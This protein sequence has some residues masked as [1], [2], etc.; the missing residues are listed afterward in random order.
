MNSSQRIRVFQVLAGGPWG[1]GA[2][3]VRALTEELIRRG[4]Q[5]WV[6]CLS[7]EVSQRFSE[8]GAHVVTSRYWRRAINPRDVLV[9]HE[10]FSLCRRTEFDVVHTHTS[11]GGFLGRIAAKSAGVAHII[12]TIHGFSFNELT[13]WW[14]KAFY[15][16]LERLA[17]HFGDVTISV[18]EQHR[19]LAIEKGI[20]RP[21]Q[22]I[23]IHNGI[24]LTRFPGTVAAQSG[25]IGSDP[26]DKAIRIGTVGRLTPQKGQTYL[27]RA[28]P[29]VV[30]KHPEAH[31]LF[32]G[33]G[34]QEDELRAMAVALGV[35]DH[36][37]FL[38]FRRDVPEL[39]ARL[40]V[41]VQPSPR[42]G[43]SIT[44]LEAM[45]AG[46]PVVATDITGNQEVI[47]DGING[48]LCQPKSSAALS[49]AI[50]ALI[51]NREE[52]RLLG[53]RARQKVEKHFDQRIMLEQTLRLYASQLE[54][55]AS[56]SVSS[57]QGHS[58]G[59]Q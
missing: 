58:I 42:E 30:R 40:D 53:A 23:T 44:L 4:S 12:H 19:A 34:P 27:L 45:A 49:E 50:I 25:P 17:S 3:V 55:T 51:D 18:T 29:A 39:L 10:L 1:G 14:K 21:N 41:F 9:L 33:D 13:P 22:V 48:V 24:D 16:Q 37:S 35:A 2:V 28:F 7:E 20:A 31:L 56:P 36:C 11:K 15:V 6:L 32:I 26:A 8:I 43:L 54:S 5:V 57:Y 38:G 59:F 46:K 47:N 52:A